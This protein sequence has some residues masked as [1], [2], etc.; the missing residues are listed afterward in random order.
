MLTETA[1]ESKNEAAKRYKEDDHS[2][3][4]WDVSV[5]RLGPAEGDVLLTPTVSDS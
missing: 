2:L 1:Q 5:S 4:F 3:T